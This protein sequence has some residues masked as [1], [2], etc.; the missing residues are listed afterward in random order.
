MYNLTDL[1]N[2]VVQV[3]SQYAS[4]K[5][6]Q[7]GTEHILYALT[8]VESKAKRLLLSYRVDSNIVDE[9]LNKVGG[10]VPSNS[11]ELT[12]RTKEL[13]LIA[14]SVAKRTRSQYISTEHL[15]VSLLSQEDSF[16]INVLAGVLKINVYELRTRVIG[17]ISNNTNSA[18]GIINNFEDDGLVEV[19]NLN[20]KAN[21]QSA[22]QH[23]FMS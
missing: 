5:G 21:P 6:N 14:S 16:A 18:N 17:I 7:V 19:G 9:I 12:P 8:K 22:P 13:L 11:I 2:R 10:G 4:R 23:V 20:G 15:L 1:A 3:A